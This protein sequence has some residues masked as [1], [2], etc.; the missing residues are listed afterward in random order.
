MGK[1]SFHKQSSRGSQ[2][3]VTD[4]QAAWQHPERAFNNAHILIKDQMSDMGT[5]QQGFDSRNQHDIV[6]PQQL[7]HGRP[8][9]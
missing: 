2:I 5:I 7:P 8:L 9:S 3:V 1:T 4:Q 6:G